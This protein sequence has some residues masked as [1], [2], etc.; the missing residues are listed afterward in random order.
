MV[1][2]I[3][4]FGTSHISQ[5]SLELIDK[6]FEEEKPDIVA[7]ELDFVRL[8]SLNREE[9]D[10]GGPIFLRLLRYFQ[11]RLGAKTGLMPGEEMLYAYERALDQEKD[12]ALIDQDIR[13]TMSK[14][15]SIRR[16]EK[17][18]AVL[19]I[20]TGLSFYRKF[21]YHSIPEEKLLE[22]MKG[23]MKQYYPDLY[24][25]LIK[26]RDLYMAE[27]LLKLSRQNPDSK[28]VAFVGAG[29]QKGIENI[30]ESRRDNSLE[31]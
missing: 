8:E 2:D 7:L 17:V 28:I 4:V 5:E 14:L 6:A 25:V 22:E 1:E 13:V 27:S 31:Q 3:K 30:I 11:K 9:Q 19:S 16:K 26:E 21:D 18:K 12:V 24:E 15:R 10:K 20:F 23:E 29:H